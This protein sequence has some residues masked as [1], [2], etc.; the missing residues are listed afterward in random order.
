MIYAQE[1]KSAAEMASS[2]V[3]NVFATLVSKVNAVTVT[4]KQVAP[5]AASNQAAKE[6]VPAG[7]N[8]FAGNVLVT[9][10]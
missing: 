4:W 7:V 8:V 9:T 2:S 3:E 6:F 1:N 5:M 10:V